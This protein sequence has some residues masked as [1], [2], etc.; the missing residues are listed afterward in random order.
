[1]NG[2]TLTNYDLSHKMDGVRKNIPEISFF[3]EAEQLKAMTKLPHYSKLY[4]GAIHA[5][6]YVNQ[7]GSVA[8]PE[9]MQNQAEI[10]AKSNPD[11]VK[12][13]CIVGKELVERGLNCLHAVGMGG[14][15]E[16]RLVAIHYKGKKESDEFSHA[17][18]GKGVTFDT[19]GLNLKP[20]GGIE[21]M[22]LDKGGACAVLG[23]MKV[24]IETKAAVN[25]IGCMVLA[26]NAIDNKSY[27][28]SD[29]IK[30]YSGLTV[31]VD[32][33][34]AEGRL[35]LMDGMSYIQRNYKPKKLVDICT[36]TGAIIIALGPE[37]AG[38]FSND[39]EFAKEFEEAAKDVFEKSWRMPVGEEYDEFVKAPNA[40]LSNMGA[41]PSGGASKAASFL[42]A[43]VE[44]D[45]KWVHFDI[46]GT[47]ISK[48]Q[49]GTVCRGGTGFGANTLV[50]LVTKQF[51]SQ[52]IHI[53]KKKKK[54][55]KLIQ[56]HKTKLTNTN[57][58]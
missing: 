5:R 34:D 30:S 42:K 46:A 27:H 24:L 17:F 4:E 31:V 20:T 32:N 23:A 13:E 10:L 44:K 35:C 12:L 16:P 3:M 28:P 57:S 11:A 48:S 21:S 22:Y 38:L 36:L 25:V 45:V 56:R 50:R 19:G 18:V 37:R 14:P 58:N 40:D 54:K 53:Q 15:S 55:N 47:A 6:N 52:L 26:E 39:D 2:I 8:T 51:C 9:Y 33:T 7:T 43:V 41:P 49:S 1:M 29:I